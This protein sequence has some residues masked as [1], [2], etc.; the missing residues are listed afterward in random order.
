MKLEVEYWILVILLLILI[1]IAIMGSCNKFVP[2]SNDSLFTQEFGYEGFSNPKVIVD[3][4]QMNG[5]QVKGFSGFY[6]KANEVK[7]EID[8]F[9]KGKGS[10]DTTQNTGLT[11][12]M[13]KI[14][15]DEEAYQLLTSRGGNA[16][17]KTVIE[18]EEKK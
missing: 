6:K 10:K 18:T 9:S 15:V 2:Y 4:E 17:P 16:S 12:S 13:G 14:E 7:E 3:E 5:L 11:N 1:S 8:I